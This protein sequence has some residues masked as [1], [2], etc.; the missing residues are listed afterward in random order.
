MS[1]KIE[2][3]LEQLEP[4]DAVVVRLLY[5]IL[6]YLP[7]SKT[8]EKTTS[9]QLAVL[10]PDM[11][12]KIHSPLVILIIQ[13]YKIT[14]E[15]FGRILDQLIAINCLKIT[16][17]NEDKTDLFYSQKESLEAHLESRQKTYLST[18]YG[19]R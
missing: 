12:I 5:D 9:R 1:N 16:D 19:I 6:D 7:M 15:D 10:L 11:L 2:T 13:R 4:R 17:E 3:Y 18:K 14:Y 8:N